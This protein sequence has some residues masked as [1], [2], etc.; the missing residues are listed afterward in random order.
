MPADDLKPSS[1]TRQPSFS[2][3]AFIE[4]EDRGGRRRGHMSLDRSPSPQAAGG[5]SSPGLTLPYEETN[6]RSRSPGRR[7]G[8]LNGGVTW[9][10]AKAGSDRVS[11]GYPRYQSQNEGFFSRHYRRI[12]EGLPYFAH[13]GQE[14]RLVE[15]ERLGRGRSWGN[16]SVAELPRR[17]GLLLSRRRKYVALAVMLLFALLLWFQKRESFAIAANAFLSFEYLT[18]M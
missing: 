17:L 8:A 14:D 5:W 18:R 9:A 13:G 10:T 4:E 1:P 2:G 3:H 15:K 6:G 12:S 16:F 11:R 7:Y